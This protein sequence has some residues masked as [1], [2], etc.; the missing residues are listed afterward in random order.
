M[1]WPISNITWETN[2]LI[3]SSGVSL[4][5]YYHDKYT[6][7][8]VKDWNGNI[9]DENTPEWKE[10]KLYVGKKTVKDAQKWL[11]SH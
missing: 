3:S 4:L 5:L 2:S 11:S 1:S 6:L 9:Y 10:A 7:K 8:E